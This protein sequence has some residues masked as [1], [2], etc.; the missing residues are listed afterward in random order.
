MNWRSA[1]SAAL[2]CA[3][4]VSTGCHHNKI[5]NPLAHVDSKQPDK[6]LFDRAQDAIKHGRY[7]VGRNLLT[8]MINTYPDSEF[9]ARAKLSI[10]DSWYNEGNSASYAQAEREYKDFR[11]FFPNMPEAAEAQMRIADIHYNEMGKPDRDYTQA[12]RAEDEYREMISSYPDHKLTPIAKQRLRDVQE[13]LAEG[14]FRVAR[15]YYTRESWPA[16][17]ARLKTVADTYPLY[18]NADLSLYLLGQAYEAESKIMSNPKLRLRENRRQALLAEFRKNAIDAYSRVI[19]RYPA[20]EYA[21]GAAK[22][23]QAL[24]APVPHATPEAIARNKQEIESRGSA[25]MRAKLMLNFSHRPDVATAAH[26]GDPPME[27]PRQESAPA[28]TQRANRILNGLEE[29][30]SGKVSAQ[31]V[32]RNGNAAPTGA[33][34]SGAD[35]G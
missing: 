28:L 13:V 19:E 4:V 27:D 17:I 5:N 16:A 2:L 10:A 3:A 20:G 34:P 32:D 15:F 35:S 1:A 12:K 14:Q 29:P 23:L 33:Q 31:V 7:D 8:T 26:V 30:A 18:S 25:S 11:A 22:R 24:E 9:V 21:D 6:V